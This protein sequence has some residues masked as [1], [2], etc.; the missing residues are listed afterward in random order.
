MTTG[1]LNEAGLMDT[2]SPVMTQSIKCSLQIIK[3]GVYRIIT[4]LKYKALLHTSV[5]GLPLNTFT[6]L[7]P[8]IDLD[9]KKCNHIIAEKDIKISDD[10]LERI[11]VIQS[12]GSCFRKVTSYLLLYPMQLT[13]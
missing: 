1:Q 8:T 4:T 5:K 2:F 6:I 7:N 9:L 12:W 11:K 3:P 10:F 13:F